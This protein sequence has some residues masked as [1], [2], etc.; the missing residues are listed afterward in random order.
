[1]DPSGTLASPSNLISEHQVDERRFSKEAGNPSIKQALLGMFSGLQEYACT[2]TP[3]HTG[4]LLFTRSYPF[5]HSAPWLLPQAERTE[6]AK[7][8]PLLQQ[9]RPLCSPCCRVS[10][11]PSRGGAPPL[12][13]SRQLETTRLGCTLLPPQTSSGRDNLLLVEI[14]LCVCVYKCVHSTV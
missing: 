1:M 12:P 14:S 10:A 4:R 2:P 13:L 7:R 11:G 9:P 6:E 5:I 8:P 3:P